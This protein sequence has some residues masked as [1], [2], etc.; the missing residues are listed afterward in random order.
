[1]GN[2]CIDNIAMV[3]TPKIAELREKALALGATK[4]HVSMVK[5]K[6]FYVV[7]NGKKINFGSET[8]ETYLD[9]QDKA[10][11]DAWRARHTKI[12]NKKGQFVYKLKT[13]ASFWAYHLLW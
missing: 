10:K 8:S 11:R 12:Q 5:N 1:M 6:R 13:S 7:Y 2:I 3:Y 9:H 4:F